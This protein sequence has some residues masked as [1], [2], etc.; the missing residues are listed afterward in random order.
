VSICFALAERYKGLGRDELAR[1]YAIAADDE[2]RELNG[3]PRQTLNLDTPAE[4]FQQ[5]V[6][7]TG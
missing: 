5:Y 4:R 3:R 6:A 7:L 2:A 1:S